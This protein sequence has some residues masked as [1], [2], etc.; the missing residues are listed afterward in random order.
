MSKIWVRTQD[1]DELI[2]CDG[3]YVKYLDAYIIAIRNVNKYQ[4]FQTLGVYSTKE[5]ALEVLNEIE[6]IINSDDET[7]VYHMPKD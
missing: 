3:F 1:E 7:G 2:L 5:R 6:E 4:I